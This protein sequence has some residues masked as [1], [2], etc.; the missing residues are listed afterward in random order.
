[1]CFYREREME[2]ETEREREFN[3]LFITLKVNVYINLYSKNQFSLI[4]IA[5][6]IF[7]SNTLRIL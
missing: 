4:Y 3:M 1:M 5:E 2:Q 6:S 7:L